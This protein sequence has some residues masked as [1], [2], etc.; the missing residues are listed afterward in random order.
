MKVDG[1]FDSIPLA[2][3]AILWPLLGAALIVGLR[4]L[5]PNWL[6]RSLAALATL[7]SLVTLWSLRNG[8]AAR[9]MLSWEPINLFRTSPFLPKAL[10]Q[11]PIAS[12]RLAVR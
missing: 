8:E 1:M 9:L 3:R 7:A 10:R 4:R 2:W 12:L 6:R 5:L 11:W